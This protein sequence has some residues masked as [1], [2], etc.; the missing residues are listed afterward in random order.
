M[1]D[2]KKS[3]SKK[4]STPI[5]TK[6][7]SSVPKPTDA[8]VAESIGEG[9]PSSEPEPITEPVADNINI[10][11]NSAPDEDNDT[12]AIT[13]GPSKQDVSEFLQLLSDFKVKV[14]DLRERLAPLI[15]NMQS[16]KLPTSSGVSLLEV[17]IHNMLSYVTNIAYYLLLKLHGKP[18]EG[19][20]V[21]SE[22][23]ELRIVLE[24]T[25]PLEQKLKYQIEKLVKAAS[26]Q[27][28]QSGGPIEAD[29]VAMDPLQF[30]PNPSGMVTQVE[31]KADGEKEEEKSGLYRPPKVAPMHYEEKV[32]KKAK[33]GKLTAQAKERASKSR[34]L[35]DLKSQFDNRPEEMTAEGTGYGAREVGASRD[36][37][38]WTEREQF[39][40]ENFT[41][42]NVTREDKKLEKRL[43][44]RG[45]Q[46]RF[47]DE[48]QA[49]E[50]DFRDFSSVQRAVEQEDEI[51]FGRGA[52]QKAKI[53]ADEIAKS[54]KYKDAGDFIEAE[55][56]KKRTR[57]PADALDKQLKRQRQAAAGVPKK[58]RSKY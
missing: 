14:G 52:L 22:L 12:Q 25:K 2:T 55:S 21:I 13:S 40:E 31:K 35:R 49:L 1:V 36:D 44:D 11:G 38:K 20:G 39:E 41:R 56:R 17:K 27:E 57:G 8:I 16:G 26:M 54:G 29:G 45:A 4:K 6:K 28:D 50:E 24:K 46:M 48:F 33:T 9:P 19:N 30:K 23:V 7:A 43:R 47:Q 42:L 3:R 15:A 58:R 32:G 34:L 18:V 5:S 53:H 10:D 51:N 37:E